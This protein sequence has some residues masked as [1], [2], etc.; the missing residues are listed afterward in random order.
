MPVKDPELRFCTALAS[1]WKN[2]STLS[3]AP[4]YSFLCGGFL[5]DPSNSIKQEHLAAPFS[6]DYLTTN[7][8]L[9]LSISLS[10][11]P[12]FHPHVLFS[13]IP[14]LSE[15]IWRERCN[16]DALLTFLLFNFSHTWAVKYY[17]QSCPLILFRI[18]FVY[19]IIFPSEP[20]R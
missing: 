6:V 16:S 1:A 17:S 10:L 15:E 4:G 2:P 11:L 13:S 19:I 20:S 5:K 9:D 3:Y 14:Q 7:S 12:S 8:I 18:L